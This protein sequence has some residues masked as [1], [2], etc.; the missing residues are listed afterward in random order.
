MNGSV[1]LA[2]AKCPTIVDPIQRG[3][4]KIASPNNSRKAAK[5]DL[6]GGGVEL[7]TAAQPFRALPLTKLEAR[8]GIEP[9][10]KDLQSSASPLRHRA[11]TPGEARRCLLFRTA[12]TGEY[13]CRMLLTQGG[14]ARGP[15]AGI[16]PSAILLLEALM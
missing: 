11:S 7:E 9:G 12:S 1:G 6:G 16:R 15:I 10:C 8:P 4:M 5:L 14:A 2:V 3:R 13:R